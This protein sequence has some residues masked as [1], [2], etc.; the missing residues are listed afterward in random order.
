MHKFYWNNTQRGGASNSSAVASN[1]AATPTT[2]SSQKETEENGEQF[3]MDLSAV[4]IRHGHPE[5]PARAFG[6]TA[7][8]KIGKKYPGQRKSLTFQ[9][10]LCH[11]FLFYS[12]DFVICVT[13]A[14][15][16]KST[17]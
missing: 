9:L 3:N 12:N 14:A 1:A 13:A 11:I 6:A 2:T 10:F 8:I 7:S 17:V 5:V 15:C 4:N 16:T